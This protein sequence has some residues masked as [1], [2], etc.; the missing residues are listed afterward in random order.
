MN[1]VTVQ[2][3]RLVVEPVGLDKLWGPVG[4]RS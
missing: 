3:D 2:P 4:R 1:I